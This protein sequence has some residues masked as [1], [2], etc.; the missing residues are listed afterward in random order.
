MV[1]LIY[2]Y[3]QG[4]QAHHAD[5]HPERP[6]R[7]DIVQRAL[8]EIGWW[9]PYPCLPPAELSL[10]F[11]QTI[12]DPVY[13][14]TLQVACQKGIQLDPDTYTTPASWQ[15]AFNA[16]GGAAAV[17]EAVWNSGA[18][19]DHMQFVRGFALSR[20]PGHHAERGRGM[21]FCLLNNVAIA[22]EHLL[23][24]QL[25][26]SPNAN[27]VAI[28]DLDLHH[29]NGT[30][31]IFW[32]RD[33]VF[34]ISTHQSPLYPGTG[35]LEEMGE[36]QGYGYNLNLPFPPGTGDSGYHSAMDEVILPVLDRFQPQILL[37]SL[38]FDP[39]WRDPL[40]HLM[41]TSAGY[42]VILKSLVTWADRNCQG[43]IVYVMEGGYDPLSVAACAQASVAA[44]LGVEAVDPLGPP[45][46]PEGKS[47]QPV[48]SRAK[49]LWQLP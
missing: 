29:G 31:D 14:T 10:D 37:V 20:P 13:L 45:P 35:F 38:G 39:H 44:L 27:R 9:D 26:N 19:G 15:L 24:G 1:D 33:D 12:H 49:S 21:G 34:Y 48:I 28:I 22:A 6:E 43:R 2:Y 11:I 5:G 4:H 32:G 23:S 30:Q 16:A 42:G 7:I 47:W 25:A 36:R 18:I 41:L 8:H 17:A 3:P 40:G 46:R